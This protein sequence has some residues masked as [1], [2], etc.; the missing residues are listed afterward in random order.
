MEGH[1]SG[2]SL[3]E[4]P[5]SASRERELLAE[6]DALKV[7]LRV[8]CPPHAR[9]CASMVPTREVLSGRQGEIA[10]GVVE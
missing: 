5:S 2:A 10:S 3:P 8:S 7:R 6:L 9:E 1:E 4:A